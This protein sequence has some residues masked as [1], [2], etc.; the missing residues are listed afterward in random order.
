MQVTGELEMSVIEQL[1]T[2]A[3]ASANKSEAAK[4]ERRQGYASI[5]GLSMYFEIHGPAQS[6]ARPLLYI[7]M[8]FGVA[9][10]TTFPKLTQTRKLITVDL[11]GRGRTADINR[12]LTFEQQAE[13]VAALLRHLRIDRADLLGECVGGIVAILVAIRH[14]ELVG[15]IITYGTAFGKF[16]D[17]YKPEILAHV[18]TLTPDSD[19]VRYQRESY[20]RVAPDPSHW[21][22]IWSKFNSTPWNGFSNEEL[23][24]LKACVLIAIGSH[25]WVRIEHAVETYNKIPDSELAVVPDAG[26]FA[27]AAE[28]HK[29]MPIFGLFLDPPL[30]KLPF[31]TTAVAYQPGFSR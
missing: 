23:G 8:G 9:G 25:D 21:P 1:T 26:H 6:T 13:D 16:Q 29:V 18:M 14:P 31:A 3:D 7:P 27:L 24:R 28:Q 20:Q 4:V 12:P 30:K 5:N 15:R 11:Q 22:A 10:T 2:D 19:V 17:A